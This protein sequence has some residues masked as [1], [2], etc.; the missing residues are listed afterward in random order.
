[1]TDKTASFSVRVPK[2]IK[3]IMANALTRKCF[4]GMA[5]Q[6]E[7][8]DIEL[9]D[10]GIVIPEDEDGEWVRDMAHKFNVDVKTFKRRIEGMR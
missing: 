7:C 10:N 9:G 4:E 3:E 8:G 5:R 6:I 1:M 2:E